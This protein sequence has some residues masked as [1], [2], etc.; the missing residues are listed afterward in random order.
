MFL[1][2]IRELL[3][4]MNKIT[5]Y[6]LFFGFIYSSEVIGTVTI[7]EKNGLDR[8][9]EYVEIVISKKIIDLAKGKSILVIDPG[10]GDTINCQIT[11]NVD[12]NNGQYQKTILFPINIA[13]YG[14]HTF[15][16]VISDVIKEK[17]DVHNKLS[18]YLSGEGTELVIK[19]EYYL[20]DLR[21]DSTEEEKSYKSGQI[22]DLTIKL[23]FNQ[24]L[25]NR[26]DRIHWAP[27][28]KR[29]ELEYYKT[30]AHW[31]KPKKQWINEGEYLVRTWRRDKAPAHPEIM[32]SALYSFYIDKPYFVFHSKMEMLDDITLE[33]LRNDEMT[34]DTMFTHLAFKR[35]S[36]EIID[37]PL[38]ERNKIL[39]NN[40][41]AV[42]DPWLCFYNKDIGYA[43]GSIRIN[44]DIK[45]ADGGDSNVGNSY[46]SI[47][48]WEGRTTY[49]NRR[50]IYNDL[51]DVKKGSKYIENN[52]YIVFDIKQDDHLG[53]IK[54]WS[55]RLLSPLIVKATFNN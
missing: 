20:A 34:M 23:G 18:M 11:Q 32:L 15:E 26:D 46:T 40:P 17:E 45:N 16:I 41:I 54:Y 55:D 28:F 19:N 35:K 21:A 43:F 9:A 1:L 30:I 5:L 52:A 10:L 47:A 36:G 7:Y 27:N 6:L 44:Y 42:D 53:T 49:W 38:N 29:P 22:R 48:E 3:F 13:A 4:G 39:D 37:I 33:L 8:T 2:L 31:N 25:T 24:L 51:V 14:S 50:L 12:I